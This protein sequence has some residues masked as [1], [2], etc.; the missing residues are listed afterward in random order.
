M[1]GW[2]VPAGSRFAVVAM[3]STSALLVVTSSHLSASAALGYAGLVL[4]GGGLQAAT[5]AVAAVL[6]QD[7]AA[8]EERAAVEPNR[9]LQRA[10]AIR[11]GIGIATATALYRY[12]P[13]T[14]GF[15]LPVAV[16]WVLK[17]ELH[18]T[19]TRFTARILGTLLGGV[20]VTLLLAL[21]K[22]TD[23]VLVVLAA[24]LTFSSYTLFHASYT[25]FA[26]SFTALIVVMVSFT[27]AQT[28]SLAGARAVDTILG[29]LVALAVFVIW[30]IRAT[31]N[32]AAS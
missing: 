19:L 25:A 20:A 22:P 15:W 13:G 17:P 21:V 18:A 27:G 32:E 24:L 31:K 26:A 6:R 12:L 11:L 8:K 4:V 3:L 7:D 28:A 10:H 2:L 14:R 1:A 16:L 9:K 29:G 30:P 23:A 5:A